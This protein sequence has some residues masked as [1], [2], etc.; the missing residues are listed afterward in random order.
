MGSPRC[1]VA[2]GLLKVPGKGVLQDGRGRGAGRASAANRG[3]WG[4]G[5]GVNIFFRG[6]N[7]HQENKAHGESG[8]DHLGPGMGPG[9]AQA[10]TQA[11]VWMAP[12]RDS[13]RLLGLSDQKAEIA[14]FRE[15]VIHKGVFEEF[16]PSQIVRNLGT[17][18]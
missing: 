9:R 3:I 5:G 1:R 18:L 8:R 11:R 4:G 15:L 14:S 2:G 6:R 13:N 10:R 7:V 16:A 12:P 17:S